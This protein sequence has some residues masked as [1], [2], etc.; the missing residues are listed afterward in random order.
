VRVGFFSPLPP[1]RTGV[2]DYSAALLRALRKTGDV[3]VNNSRADVA[4]YHLGN[5]GLHRQIYER[6]LERPGVVV[7]HDAVLHHFF[8]GALEEPAYIEEFVYN[9]GAWTEDL[10]REL[11]RRRA[12]SGGDA[13]YFRYPMLRR[14]AER[15][16]AVIVHNPAAARMVREHAPQARVY[17]I[18]HLFEAGSEPA[19]AEIERLRESLGVMPST[20]LFGVLGHLRESKRVPSVVRAFEAVRRCARAALLVAGDMVSPE[21]E[22][23]MAPLFQTGVIRVPGL[24][25]RTWWLHAH[26]TDV[27][28]NLR[29]PRAGETSGI[30]VRMMGIGRPVI[31]TAGEFSAAPCVP[32]DAGPAEIEMLAGMMGW[33][34]GSR[35]DRLAIGGAARRYVRDQH[36][37][38][39]VARQYWRVLEE[40][41]ER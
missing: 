36:D 9:Y 17:E 39:R 18:P 25:E 31:V 32:I 27:C 26:A 2:A 38:E 19:G 35:D 15:S 4:L 23:A 29:Y 11:W 16:A 6:A 20:V 22:R 3:R 28:V 33:L 5:N 1:A 34:A 14:I 24:P 41:R 12:N 40:C 30:G 7:L 21:Y 13:E 8:L 10:A 37:P